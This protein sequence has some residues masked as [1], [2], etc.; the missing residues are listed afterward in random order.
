IMTSRPESRLRFVSW[1]TNGIKDT[2]QSEEKISKLLDSLNNL[3][4]DVAFIQETHIGP[5]CYKILEDVPGWNVYFTVYSSRSKGVAI[6]IKNT[7]PF[8]Y[9]CHDED[10][11]GS[12]IVLFCRLFGELHTLVNI[13]YHKADGFFLA[14]LKDY[15]VETA[16]GVL[17]VGGDFNTVLHPSFDR[18][19][20]SSQARHSP[21]RA[22]L[23]YFT[24]SLNLRD[25]W[26][27]LR[28]TDEDY[29]RRQN[30]SL[31]RID[32]FFLPEHR[33]ERVR[34][35][36]VEHNIAELQGFSDHHPLVLDLT[37][38]QNVNEILPKVASGV[39][40]WCKPSTPDRRP[41][42][43]SGAEILSVI[44]SLTELED[45][46]LDG[47]DVKY[48]KNNS[49][50]LSES[51]K[52]EYNSVI[53]N[54][55]KLEQT[56]LSGYRHIFNLQ[57]SILSQILARRLSALI[58]MKGTVEI[59][60][61]TFFNVKF[62]TGLQKIKWHF[63]RHSIRKLHPELSDSVHLPELR[64]LDYLL[65]KDPIFCE[66][67]LLEPGYP[68]T[69]AIFCL[70]LNELEEL[71]LDNNFRGTV[72]YQ[73]QVLRIHTPNITSDSRDAFVR[74]VNNILGLK[75]TINE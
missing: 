29:T 62:Q 60:H 71:A 48:Y 74:H 67:R 4:A 10:C 23:E 50:E 59:N 11:N 37:V 17:V 72:C 3:Q 63:L 36:T 21:F 46:P 51:L 49:C 19:S 66:F 61:D 47:K 8:E 42:K 33:M 9:I 64:F 43:I 44:K 38:R 18:K 69:N 16:E 52:I 55:Q 68:L 56:N 7:V 70:A 41:G 40:L 31:S 14:R 27:Y 34:R 58:S 5:D 1:N 2:T 28:P 65:P 20:S 22:S 54:K 32:M 15:L 73:R 35:I 13:Y 57:Y 26:S 30:D 24:V 12:Y 45:L 25:T 75:I 53:Q 6:L 39:R